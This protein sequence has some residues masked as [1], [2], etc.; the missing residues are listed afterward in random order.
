MTAL[1][2]WLLASTLA[3][4][5]ADHTLATNVLPKW[6]ALPLMASAVAGVRVATISSCLDQRHCVSGND[7]MLCKEIELEIQ[8]T[9]LFVP[10]LHHQIE[11]EVEPCDHCG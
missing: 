7:N 4:P 8:F 3:L 5:S 2:R 1:S 9:L 6:T 10:V 11:M